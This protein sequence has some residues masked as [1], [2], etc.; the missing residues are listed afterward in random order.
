MVLKSLSNVEQTYLAFFNFYLQTIFITIWS[1]KNVLFINI[2]VSVHKFIINRKRNWKCKK[3]YGSAQHSESIFH[4][5]FV[6]N[7]RFE[8]FWGSNASKFSTISSP[9]FEQVYGQNCPRLL[10]LNLDLQPHHFSILGV[11]LCFGRLKGL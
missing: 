6:K 2:W 5:S 7:S 11:E 8:H 3:R 4:F 9:N 1:C 10:F